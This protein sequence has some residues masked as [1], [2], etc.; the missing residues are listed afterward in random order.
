MQHFLL[1]KEKTKKQINLNLSPKGAY[2]SVCMP[3]QAGCFLISIYCFCLVLCVNV[4]HNLHNQVKYSLI[5]EAG[6]MV[7]VGLHR[8]RTGAE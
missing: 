8:E 3:N 6:L 4:G 1:F 2:L 7:C 5:W